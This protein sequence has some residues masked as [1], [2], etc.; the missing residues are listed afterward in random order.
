VENQVCEDTQK[1]LWK[2]IDMDKARLWKDEEG[3]FITPCLHSGNASV[4]VTFA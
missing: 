2:E 4:L 1:R 3:F